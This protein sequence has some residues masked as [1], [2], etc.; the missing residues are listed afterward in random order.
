[1]AQSK[2]LFTITPMSLHLALKDK[3]FAPLFWTQFL[4]ALNDNFLKNSLVL[5]ITFKNVQVFGLGA[6]ELVALSGGIFILPFF[7]FST[8]S[9]QLADKIEKTL[10]IRATKIGEIIIAILAAI[11]FYFEFYTGLL[12]ILF[13]MGVHSTFFGP[14]KYS[15]IPDLVP[16]NKLTAANAYVELG[17]FVAILVGTIGGGLAINFGGSLWLI[18]TGLIFVAVLG[19]WAST[20]IPPVQVGQPDL[21][22]NLNPFPTMLAFGKIIREQKLIF[23]SI[24]GIS[25]FWFFGAAVLSLLPV[26]GKDFLGAGPAVITAFLASFTVGIGLGSIICEKLSSKRVEL[27]LVPIGSLGISVFLTDLFF[28]SPSWTPASNAPLSL[29]LFFQHFEAWRIFGDFFLMSVFSG[30]FIVPLYTLIQQRSRPESRSR[31]IAGNNIL[32]SVFMVTSSLLVMSLHLIN[33]SHPQIFLVLAFL[34]LIF[35]IYIFS[36][37]PEFIKS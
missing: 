32:N 15:I 20:K 2:P 34:N 29:L 13:L 35:S 31:V 1:M 24:L 30:L 9:G 6:S 36:M 16:H 7:L 5:M 37:T 19:L 11:G 33:L 22:I 26:Y 8:H 10:L 17:T 28:V 3:R 12:F 25:W 23:N 21:K 4:G 27:K 14:V 18:I